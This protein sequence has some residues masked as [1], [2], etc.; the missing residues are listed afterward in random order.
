MTT[1]DAPEPSRDSPPEPSPSGK[2]P[3][4][5]CAEEIQAA[6]V[7]CR[8]CRAQK[9]DAGEWQPQ[10][11]EPSAIPAGKPGAF[12]I[13]T[14]AVLFVISAA[15]EVYSITTPVPLFGELRGGA[16]GAAHHLLF[17][18]LFLGVGVGLWRATQWGY[19]LVFVTTGI[20]TLDRVLYAFDRKA[21]DAQIREELASALGMLGRGSMDLLRET[22]VAMVA[23]IVVCWWGFALYIRI[24]REYFQQAEAEVDG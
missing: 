19:Y 24:R 14:A 12:T 9:D 3:C 11:E 15:Y 18:A 8:F 13:Q 7:L 10:E 23:V 20:Y 1:P 5:F 21:M 22:T 17:C 16:V 6:A 2:V 4:P